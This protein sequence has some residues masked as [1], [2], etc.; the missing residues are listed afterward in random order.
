MLIGALVLEFR[1]VLGFGGGFEWCVAWGGV[2]V[3]LFLCV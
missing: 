2:G 3:G 1:V